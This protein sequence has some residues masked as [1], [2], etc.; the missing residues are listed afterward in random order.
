MGQLAFIGIDDDVDAGGSVRI[1]KR[2]TAR[3]LSSEVL[4]AF[5]NP[6]MVMSISV[7]LGGVSGHQAAHVIV[8]RDICFSSAQ[9]E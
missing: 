9:A 8:G 2:L 6:I 3:T 5:C 4:P 1:R 7:A